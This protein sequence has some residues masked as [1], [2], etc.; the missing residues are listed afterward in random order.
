MVV[1]MG[2]WLTKLQDFDPISILMDFLFYFNS[3][4]SIGFFILLRTL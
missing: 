3:S 4:I 1:Y 2:L